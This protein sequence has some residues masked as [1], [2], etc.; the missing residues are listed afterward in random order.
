MNE[1]KLE[2]I[3]KLFE[4]KDIRMI[5]D[6]EKEEYYFS[7]VDVCGALTDSK[8]PS[9]YW[10]TLKRRLSED[11]K[12]ELPTLCRKLKMLTAKGRNY[13]TDTLDVEG[14]FRL[15]QSIPSPKAEPFKLWL[16]KL[17]KV[18]VDETF[19]PSLAIDRAIDIYRKKGYA[20]DWIEKRLKGI[21]KRKELTDIWKSGGINEN[22]EYAIL[23]N[24]IYKTWSGMKA[25]EYKEFKGIRKE[26]LRDNM[27]DIEISLTDLSETVT[28]ELT[29]KYKPHGLEANKKIAQAGG[30]T[31]KVAREDIEKKLG[32]S[33]VSS[34]NIL[35]NQYENNLIE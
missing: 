8:D 24:E 21:L 10:T 15:I 5:W 12:S 33:V 11:E 29:K 6:A 30:G 28:K 19:D 18:R 17:G 23:T 32:K 34:S 7:V 3:N 13:P 35:N 4:G 20:D 25:N 31:A 22:L 2:T 26:P 16:A 1:N 9:D 14:I 27:T